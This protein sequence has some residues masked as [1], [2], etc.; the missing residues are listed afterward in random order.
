MAI[1]TRITALA[2]LALTATALSACVTPGGMPQPPAQRGVFLTTTQI[3]M[4]DRDTRTWL[5]DSSWQRQ[6]P[7]L[8]Q[9]GLGGGAIA[10]TIVGQRAVGGRRCVDVQTW[11]WVGVV[12]YQGQP[13]A[14]RPST[15]CLGRAGY[16][17]ADAT[18]PGPVITAPPAINRGF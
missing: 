14:Q 8:V 17:L 4:G 11:Y 7:V 15:W 5:N 10:A 9:D 1:R 13:H 12:A 18:L 2:A 3:E 16:E 6:M